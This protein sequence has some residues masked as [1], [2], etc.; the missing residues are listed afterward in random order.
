M[1]VIA[2][3]IPGTVLPLLCGWVLAGIDDKA[4]IASR[5]FILPNDSLSAFLFKHRLT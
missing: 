2:S 4:R 5:R 3:V 1:L